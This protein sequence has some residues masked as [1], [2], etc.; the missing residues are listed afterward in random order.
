MVNVLVTGGSGALASYVIPRLQEDGH[1]VTAFDQVSPKSLDE[2]V[3]FVLGNLTSLEDCLRALAFA[4][5]DVIVHLGAM[6]Y[7]TEVIDRPGWRNQ[8]ILPEDET[9]KGNTMGTYYLLD[10]S[11]RLGKV[12]QVVFASSFYVLGI[13]N[14]IS[15]KPFMIDY[16]PIDEDH[17]NRPEDSYGISKLLG[18][19]ILKGFGR[20]YGIKTVAFRLLGVD[21]PFRPHPYDVKLE[22]QP[23]WVGGPI[24]STYQYVDP[25]DVAEATVLAIDAYERL[26]EFEAFYLASDTQYAEP[27][28][29]LAARVWPDLA[30]M[31]KSIEGTDGLISDARARE[32]LGYAPQHTWRGGTAE[33]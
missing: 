16:L 19:E 28:K 1:Q 23:D 21:Y 9:M 27:T 4:D 2:S 11:R 17:P 32:R 6:P 5:A 15:T 30:E 10:A 22:S 18:E 29:D 7:P 8:Q 25:R 33:A 3:P 12:K 13:G 24:I 14:R 26:D 31:A 20:A